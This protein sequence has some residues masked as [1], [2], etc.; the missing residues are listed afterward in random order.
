M[1]EKP[2]KKV[3]FFEE[4]GAQGDASTEGGNGPKDPDDPPPPTLIVIQPATESKE[5]KEEDD[6][7]DD[8]NSS[9]NNNNNITPID[10]QQSAKDKEK[11][12]QDRRESLWM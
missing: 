10:P 1:I 6:K 12:A 7:K 2:N 9:S 11:E 3:R 5:E 4:N 8:Q